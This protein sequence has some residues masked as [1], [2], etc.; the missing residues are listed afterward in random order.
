MNHD[1]H[2]FWDRYSAKFNSIYG[3]RNDLF[4]SFIN[5]CFR[6]S[7]KLRFDRT[8]NSIPGTAESVLDIGCG[9]GHYC[10]ALSGKKIPVVLGIDSSKEMIDLAKKNAERTGLGHRLEFRVCDF[11]QFPAGT[12]YDYSILM[13]FVEYFED[14]AGILRKAI[15]HTRKQV[16][17]SF[18]AAGGALAFQRKLRYR[19]RCFLKFFTREEI[20]DLLATLPIASHGIERISRDYFVTMTIR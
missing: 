16:F 12:M 5:T 4:H 3:T 6:R 15:Q 7:M 20:L 8:L 13:G 2:A 18:P 1:N 19:N 10:I 17:I 14:T 11:L 9:P